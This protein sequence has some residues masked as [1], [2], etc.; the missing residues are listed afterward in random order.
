MDDSERLKQAIEQRKQQV[1]DRQ[2]LS[3]S[4]KIAFENDGEYF[5]ESRNLRITGSIHTNDRTCSFSQNATVY[6]K[7]EL[8]YQG[9]GWM[10]TGKMRGGRVYESD[11]M[12]D[13][14]IGEDL[15]AYIPG[16]WESL[17]DKIT[18]ENE[19]K[20]KLAEAAELQDEAKRLGITSLPSESAYAKPSGSCLLLIAATGAAFA[21][22]VVATL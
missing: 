16:E 9:R 2:I 15:N 6:Y 1:I 8:V 18:K 19:E 5:S 11:N 3:K 14:S 4:A 10:T 12:S 17:V 20:E 13:W 22:L 21:A 7:G